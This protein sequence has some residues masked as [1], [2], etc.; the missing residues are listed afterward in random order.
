MTYKCEIKEMPEQPALAIR[1]RTNMQN[2]P[3]AIGE[4]FGKIIGHLSRTG[5]FP[6]GAPYVAYYNMDMADLDIEIG[7]PVG[8]KLPGN[9]EITA[10]K[11]PGGKMGTCFYTGPYPEMRV[12][13]EALA[14]LLE[15]KGLEPAGV[16][17][18]VYYNSP[19]D[20]EPSKLQTLIL[21]PLKK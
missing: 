12:A 10:S 11:L 6:A 21:F 4:G 5:D 9:G 14:K 2:L 16:V 8:K 3:R 18:E 13:Y 20:T 15:E 7:F 19:T 17:Y 1:T